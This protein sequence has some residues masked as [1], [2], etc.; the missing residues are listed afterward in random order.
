MGFEPLPAGR[1]PR[2]SR[3]SFAAALLLAPSLAAAA[4]ADLHVHLLMDAVL[5]G[6]FRGR[7]GAGPARVKGRE[8]RLRNQVSLK[9]LEAADV[10]LAAAALYAPAVLSHL[11]GGY[12]RALLRQIAELEAWAA[13]DPRVSIV[14]SPEDA[15]AVLAS[16]EWQLGVV[17]A[18][19][20]AGGADTPERLDALWERGLRML[21]I[22]HFTDTAWG[23]T[24]DVSYWPRPDCVPGGKDPGK[25]NEKGLSKAGEALSDYAVEKGLL[26]DLTHSS[27][28][29]VMDLAA[30]HPGLPLLFT[31]EAFRGYT[32][33]ERTISAELLREVRRSRGMVGVTVASNYV[34]EDLASFRRHAEALADGAG[35]EAVALGTDF[36]GMIG[37]IEGAADSSGYA[38]VL[39]EL[40]SAGI[41]A[42]RS[43]EAFVALW[44]RTNA[45]RSPRPQGIR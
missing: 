18:A 2:A 10:R 27:D 5:P 42:D 23:G 20:G 11:R 36:N 28:R 31:H 33:C 45:A 14:R 13:R 43:A 7:P 24:A 3:A 39:K 30:R 15:A 38:L 8:A 22:T 4:A 32:P 34:G 44:R 19:E 16:K 41:P 21:T 12:H 40:R 26:L 35:P 6:L 37:R 17:I 1:R 29:T 25:R 9:D